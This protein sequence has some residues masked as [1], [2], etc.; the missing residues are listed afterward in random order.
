MMLCCG[1]EALE[2]EG[3][4]MIRSAVLTCKEDD[5]RVSKGLLQRA[6]T[7][8]DASFALWPLVVVYGAAFN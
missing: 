3:E 5:E 4:S 8:L 2:E 1:D 6:E 7:P